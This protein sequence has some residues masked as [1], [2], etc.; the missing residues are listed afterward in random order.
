[1][2]IKILGALYDAT[3]VAESP[4]DPNNDALRA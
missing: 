2:R 3:V 1:M 4:F